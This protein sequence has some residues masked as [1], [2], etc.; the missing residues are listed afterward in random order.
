MAD[1]NRWLIYVKERFPLPVYFL[2]TGGFAVS[3]ALLTGE[4]LRPAPTLAAFLG[5]LFFFALLRLMDELKDYKKDLVAHPE[6]PLPRGLLGLGEVTRTIHRGAIA[7]V[8]YGIIVGIAF[9]PAAGLNYVLLT[10]YLWLMYREFY[11]GAWLEERPLLY[12]VSH[13]VVLLGLCSFPVLLANPAFAGEH[14]TWVFGLLILGSFFS[15]EVCRKLDP[16]AAPVLK[17]YRAL[18]GSRGSF[19]IVA[20]ASGIAAAAAWKLGLHP[21]LWPSTAVLLSSYFLFVGRRH[22]IV[23]AIASLSLTLHIWAVALSAAKEWIS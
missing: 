4:K 13:Q 20:V 19:A 6:R 22:K 3:G 16:T 21:M 1:R 9:N 14:R 7:M 2:L 11:A 18:Y 15:Y 8:V 12:A 10:A 23:E 5:V 17:T